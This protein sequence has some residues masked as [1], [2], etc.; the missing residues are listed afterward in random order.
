MINIR[1]RM[2]RGAGLPYPGVPI[3][4]EFINALRYCRP[5]LCRAVWE[6]DYC[7][8][9][10]AHW[11]RSQSIT[12]GL[13]TRLETEGCDLHVSMASQGQAHEA[14]AVLPLSGDVQPAAG[15]STSEQR[16]PVCLEDFEDKAFVDS[17]FHILL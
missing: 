1:S 6:R 5:S 3:R 2:G 8:P 16:C 15:A 10:P 9:H 12:S 17:C 4:F 11:Q 13:G 14:G 7:K